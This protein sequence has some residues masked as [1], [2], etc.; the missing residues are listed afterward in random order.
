MSN[1][2]S[3]RKF[4]QNVYSTVITWNLR[5]ITKVFFILSLIFALVG[6]Y[7]WY[8]RMF[9][10]NDRVFWKAI[11]N[12]MATSSVT[13]TLVSGGSGNQVT[14][15]QQFFFSPQMVSL[16][17]VQFKQD[18]ATI[19]TSVTTEG[20]AYPDSQYSRYTSFS[21]N[22]KKSDGSSPSLDTILGQ[23]EETNYPAE[24]KDDARQ[25]YVSELVTLAIFGNYDAQFRKDTLHSL[26]E[27]HVYSITNVSKANDV[28]SSAKSSEIY[29][30]LSIKLKPFARELQNAFKQAGYGEFS[31]LNEQNFKEDAKINAVFIIDRNSLSI[32]KIQF[33]NRNEA[34]QAYGLQKTVNRPVSTFT[35]GELEEIVRNEISTAL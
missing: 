35:A 32:R 2:L 20:V 26:K 28:D 16:S 25:N 29:Y 18:S 5:K 6:S 19:K 9:L 12:S 21:T 7:F 13:R 24:T 23:W 15:N 1:T 33:S 4:F 10:N 14:Q 31:A 11:E 27:S 22:Q 30:S 8:T 34:Y 3:K 17:K